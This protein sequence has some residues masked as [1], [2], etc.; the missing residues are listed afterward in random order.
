MIHFFHDDPEWFLDMTNIFPVTYGY[1]CYWIIERASFETKGRFLFRQ[2]P[3]QYDK[4]Y[5][6]WD[7]V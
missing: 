2:G 3:S 4:N 7:L 6:E 1:L 5:G